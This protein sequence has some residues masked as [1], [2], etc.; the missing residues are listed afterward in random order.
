VK[1]GRNRLV[2]RLW[3][4]Q[5]VQVSRLIRTRYG[6]VPLPKWL[7]R[8]KVHEMTPKIIYALCRYILGIDEKRENADECNN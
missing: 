8:G 1:E 3:E 7:P 2:R 5:E 4:S 6:P